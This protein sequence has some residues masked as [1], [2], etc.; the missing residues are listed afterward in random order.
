MT[1]MGANWDH[2]GSRQALQYDYSAQKFA[3]YVGF[4]PARQHVYS[5]GESTVK[6]GMSSFYL[7][8]V[9]QIH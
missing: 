6:T 7:G 4:H 1:L 5:A 9:L 8:W 2:S 3:S